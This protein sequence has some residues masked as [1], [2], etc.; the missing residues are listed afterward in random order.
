MDA[1]FQRAVQE[2]KFRE[3]NKH[4]NFVVKLLT[5]NADEHEM[6]EAAIKFGLDR[7]LATRLNITSL[8]KCIA[9]AK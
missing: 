4:V 9:V 3:L 6:V 5:E 1:N 7:K 2:G 8:S